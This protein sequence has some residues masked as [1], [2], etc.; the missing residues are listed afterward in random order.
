MSDDQH[1]ET[2]SDMSSASRET[3]DPSDYRSP[4]QDRVAPPSQPGPEML[5]FHER[6]WMDFERIILLIAE[7]VD[8]LRGVR[9]Y[10]VPGQAQLGIDLGGTDE[11]GGNVGYQPKRVRAFGAEDLDAAVQ[12][13][14]NE[15][16]AVDAYKLVVCVSCATDET[17]ISERLVDLRRSSD[18]DIDLYDRRRLSE[19]LRNRPDLVRRV[20][21]DDWAAAFCDGAGWDVPEPTREDILGEALV[22]GPIAALGLEQA[23]AA[24]SDLAEN[25][26][27]AAAAHL[28][29]VIVE[30]ERNGFEPFSQPLRRRAG[31][32]LIAAGDSANGMHALAAVVWEDVEAGVRHWDRSALSAL[33]TAAAGQEDSSWLRAAGMLE[34]VNRWYGLP[35]ADL[36]PLLEL[37][38]A[39]VE[40]QNPLVDR[41]ILWVL[42][43]AVTTEQRDIAERLV[44]LARQAIEQ[45][46][47]LGLT[48]ATTVRLRCGVADLT[49]TWT[50]LLRDARAGRLGSAMATL[51]LMRWGR[52]CTY[53]E[54]PD[55]ALAGYAEAV[56]LGCRAKV[57]AEAAAAV[58]AQT[59]IRSRYGMVSNET[60]ELHRL[61]YHLETSGSVGNLPGPDP[62]NAAT[63]ALAKNNLPEALHRH[64]GA[65]RAAVIRGDIADEQAAHLGLTDVLIRA[66]ERAAALE[67]AVRAGSV[68]NA[69]KQCFPIH[70]YV[71]PTPWLNA[72]PHWQRAAG[73][74]AL[75]QI[76]DLVPDNEIAPLIDIAL[77]A[78]DEPRRSNFGPHVDLNGWKALSALAERTT[79]DQACHALQLI[80]PRV[81]RAPNMYRFEDD[82]LIGTVTAIAGAHPQ[83]QPDVSPI[84]ASMVEQESDFADRTRRA[85][86]RQ[87]SELPVD[88]EERLHSLAAAG[89]LTAELMLDDFGTTLPSLQDAARRNV[90]DLLN[91]P[92]PPPGT[93]EFGTQL[94]AV[95]AQS[96]ALDEGTRITMAEFCATRAE[97]RSRPEANRTEGAEGVALLAHSLPVEVRQSLFERM[98]ALAAREGDPTEIDRMFMGSRHPLSTMRVDLGSGSLPREALLAAATLATQEREAHDVVSL[99]LSRLA[100][101]DAHDVEV[102]AR[103]L[104]HLDRSLIAVDPRPLLLHPSERARQVGAVLSATRHDPS[105]DDLTRIAR[106]P[107]VS[108]R[109]SLA[110]AIGVLREID[111][112]AAASIASILEDDPSWSVRRE[113]T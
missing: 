92:A 95:A 10:G 50:E 48:D 69:A 64:R 63:L 79:L 26:P 76:A 52:H 80:A 106:D 102:A 2:L 111:S 68:D 56:Q 47:P 85:V 42:E 54:R 6:S 96:N 27:A 11:T 46:A 84:L 18:F 36:A 107:G 15:R 113:L 72:V 71:S 20:F 41:L 78:I 83:L 98:V 53:H 39:L 31:A 74:Y 105:I 66:G 89:N 67:H 33:K 34:A 45:R 87:L 65:L 9:L 109:R 23:Y 61:A 86:R 38:D 70:K 13:F 22:R 93:F 112:S 57:V 3:I 19:L 108:V 29:E 88:L 91:E 55:D 1:H 94:P 32:L 99:A 90:E 97:D 12:K 21:G 73:L 62:L 17:E 104:W 75:S 40:A 5:P 14:D 82:E 110:S 81:P 59:F 100:S 4:V 28:T 44:G 49:D 35:T 16:R 8:G 103:A 30:L 7:R 37:L 101:S 58:R 77:V 60:Q 51:V 25:D 24:A 43:T